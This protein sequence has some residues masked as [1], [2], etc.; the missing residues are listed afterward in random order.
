VSSV[1]VKNVDD[2]THELLRQRAAAAGMTLGDYVLELIRK[3]LRK[4]SRAEWLA[5]VRARPPANVDHGDV[6][7]S[8]D[9]GRAERDQK[10][11]RILRDRDR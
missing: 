2:A 3:D 6:I 8:I 5:R 11:D 9:E 10:M 7:R 1:Q 4:P